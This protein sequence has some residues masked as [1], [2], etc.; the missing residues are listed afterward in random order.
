MT[1]EEWRDARSAVWQTTLLGLGNEVGQVVSMTHPDIPGRHG[2]CNV[3]GNTATWVNGDSWTYAGTTTGDTEL[4]NKVILIGSTQVTITAVASDGSTITTYPAPPSGTGLAF[5]IITMCFRIQRWTLKKDWSVQIE[6]QTVTA[7][8]YD[9]TVGPKPMDVVPEP[10]PALYYPIPSGP[11]WAPYQVQ[12]SSSDALFP[13]EW[14][15]DSDQEYTTLANGSPLAS[16]ILTGKLPVNEFSA[17]GAGAPGIGTITQTSTGG[18]LPAN[19]TLWVS[20]C[21]IDSNGLPSA[22]SNIA[23]VGTGSTSTVTFTLNGITWPAVAGLTSYVLFVGT[24]PDLICAQATGTLTAGSG[25]TYTPSSI[26]FG[27]PVARSTW[28][29]PSPYVQKVRIKA[30]PLIHAGVAGIA[31]DSVST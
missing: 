7:S 8:M 23:L 11:V 22:P 16:L 25:N 17:T 9:L 14:T 13:G 27:G 31:V 30:K 6:G 18:S 26:T 12:A 3:S 15:F 4:I 21:A 28:A 29:L 24:Q 5:Q 10:L 20:I 2:T 1:P 19:S